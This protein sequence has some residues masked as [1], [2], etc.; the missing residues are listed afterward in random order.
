MKFDAWMKGAVAG[1]IALSLAAAGV[2]QPGKGPAKM[3]IG[4]SPLMGKGRPF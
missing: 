2:A 4:R 1:A 3:V